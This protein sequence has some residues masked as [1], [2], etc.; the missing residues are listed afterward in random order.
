MRN[1]SSNKSEKE[2]AI[3]T[4][5]TAKMTFKAFP[6]PSMGKITFE[7]GL[8]EAAQTQISILNLQG[9][10]VLEINERYLSQGLHQWAWD[11][12]DQ[13]G[14]PLPNGI[15]FARATAGDRHSVLK[16]TLIR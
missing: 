15:Y 7:I 2:P 16:L 11:G 12:N 9:K 3:I 1:C 10:T 14:H 5:E 6:N 8:N 4:Q 13:Q